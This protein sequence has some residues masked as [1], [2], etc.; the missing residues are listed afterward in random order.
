LL[1]AVHALGLGAVWLGIYPREQRVNG[2]LNLI[3]LPDHIKPMAL[4][5]IGH[6]AESKEMPD[7]YDETKVHINGW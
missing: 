7:R 5:S 6:P 4:I 1:L 2:I 3:K